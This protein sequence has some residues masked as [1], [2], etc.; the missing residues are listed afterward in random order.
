MNSVSMY[1]SS[2]LRSCGILLALLA[3]M[4]SSA[5]IAVPVPLAL[6]D[7]IE[8]SDVIV[9]GTIADLD[10]RREA[11]A[12]DIYTIATVDVSKLV[13]SRQNGG[14]PQ[15]KITFRLEGGTVDGETMATSIGPELEKGDE[16]VFFLARQA[17]EDVLTLVGGQQ[18]FVPIDNGM[19]GVSGRTQP[20]GEFLDDL[21]RRLR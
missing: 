13:L 5:A 1:L 4:A 16:G 7:L 20:V 12:P 3:P 11:G 17:D 8:Q 18:G 6:E 10:S 21:A 19:V 9:H 2:I 15:R 14:A